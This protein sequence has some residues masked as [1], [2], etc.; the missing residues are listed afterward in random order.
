MSICVPCKWCTHTQ[1]QNFPCHAKLVSPF[2]NDLVHH[3]GFP[4]VKIPELGK[5]RVNCQSRSL[6]FFVMRCQE[7]C[8]LKHRVRA[9]VMLF[10]PSEDVHSF[11]GLPYHH[12]MDL[13]STSLANERRYAL[14]SKIN[15]LCSDYH[16]GTWTSIFSCY[17]QLFC[18]S[19]FTYP[20]WWL[21]GR[22]AFTILT[23]RL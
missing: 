20:E 1:L 19:S 2:F 15:L 9:A 10:E 8:N 13:S 7:A 14:S 23:D 18:Q 5:E 4:M 21:P 17:R 3:C 12:S 16:G 11:L 22:I 6:K